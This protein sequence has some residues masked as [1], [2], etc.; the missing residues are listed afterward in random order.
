MKF[1]IMLIDEGD[2]GHNR[3]VYKGKIYH[4]IKEVGGDVEN[5]YKKEI[6]NM[7]ELLE[8]KKWLEFGMKINKFKKLVK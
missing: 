8:K 7:L 4:I 2:K 5:R 3:M 6:V 1:L